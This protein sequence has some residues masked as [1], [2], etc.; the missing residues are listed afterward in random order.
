MQPL[1]LLKLPTSFAYPLATVRAGMT[2]ACIRL[3]LDDVAIGLYDR[4]LDAMAPPR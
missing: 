1:G 4:P 2:L 3:P